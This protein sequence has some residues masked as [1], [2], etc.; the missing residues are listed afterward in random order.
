MVPI[1]ALANLDSHPMIVSLGLRMKETQ[2]GFR[3][4]VAQAPC[5]VNVRTRNSVFHANA[6][7]PA[8]APDPV[9]PRQA[10]LVVVNEVRFENWHA[11]MSGYALANL[12]NSR[13]VRLLFRD[14]VLFVSICPLRLSFANTSAQFL[15]LCADV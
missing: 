14:K 1:R 15:H 5:H 9:C 10:T 6:W 13:R 4:L 11:P 2:P 8:E 12:E 7:L 3:R